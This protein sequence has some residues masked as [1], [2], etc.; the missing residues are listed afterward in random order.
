MGCHLEFTVEAIRLSLP[1][2]KG[3][4]AN[5]APLPPFSLAV[6]G[7]GGETGALT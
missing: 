3:I 6:G 4:L 5:Q 1:P 7:T 2:V